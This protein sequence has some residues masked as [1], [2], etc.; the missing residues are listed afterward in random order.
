MLAAVVARIRELR[1]EGRSDAEI[2][3][4][5]PAAAFDAK[6]GNGFIKPEG[7]VQLMLDAT[8]R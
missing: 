4:A 2:R 5:K 3:A 1:R 6:W 7:F 8:P